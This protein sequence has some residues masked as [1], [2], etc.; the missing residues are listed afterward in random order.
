MLYRKD[1]YAKNLALFKTT[2]ASGSTISRA[3]SQAWKREPESV[4]RRFE[5]ESELE[6]VR[7]QGQA[8]VPYE[9]RKRKSATMATEGSSGGKGKVS[10]SSST[11]IAA[12]K[13]KSK[14]SKTV[15]K[16]AGTSK[17]SLASGSGSGPGS[18][19]MLVMAGFSGSS[20]LGFGLGSLALSSTPPLKP[21]SVQTGVTVGSVSAQDVQAER[22]QFSASQVGDYLATLISNI[23]SKDP[24]SRSGDAG[25]A[26][27]E[28]KNKARRTK[29]SAAITATVA[30]N[31]ASAIVKTRQRSKSEGG[32]ALGSVLT[33]NKWSVASSFHDEN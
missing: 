8:P 19:R 28:L 1:V 4:K 6:R 29:S 17:N 12:N 16:G 21:G 27:V 33:P 31:A 11:A 30:A 20:S 7:Q 22:D 18:G 15:T 10:G 24:V 2:R 13:S 23:G 14:S 9:Y 26:G 3:I 5:Y 32:A 25:V